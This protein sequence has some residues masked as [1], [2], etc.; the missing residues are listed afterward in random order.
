MSSGTRDVNGR[1]N[2]YKVK[3]AEEVLNVE[4]YSSDEDG[5]SDSD[6][7]DDS[8]DE[9]EGVV[10]NEWGRKR[11]D[12]YGT[13]YVDEDWGGMRDEEADDAELE[14]EDAT[15]RQIAL[16]KAAARAADLFEK[17]DETDSFQTIAKETALEWKL[18]SVK[19]LNKR[20][21]EIIEEYNRRKDLMN[22]VVEPL[23]PVIKQLPPTSNVRKQLMLVFD[24]YTTYIMNMTF[25]LRLKADSL[26]RKKCHR[27]SSGFTPCIGKDRKI[28]KDGKER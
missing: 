6:F 27:C 18:S 9:P 16:D 19:K 11:K 15:S 14:E 2:G 7:D 3:Q 5:S 1:T 22:V 21:V 13:E 17:M 25:F 10:G 12:F 8:D 24:V 23:V 20:T 4:G 26:A 28:R